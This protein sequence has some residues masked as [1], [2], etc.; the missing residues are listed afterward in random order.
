LAD[1]PVT[2]DL[3]D[4]AKARVDTFSAQHYYPAPP[5]TRTPLIPLSALSLL[6]CRQHGPFISVGLVALAMA[7]AL[8]CY[9]WW[10]RR[11]DDV[12][13]AV[14]PREMVL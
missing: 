6:K 8:L 2:I 4:Q 10:Q 9:D 12:Y 14:P 13:E 7:A 3:V 1:D 11:R 5:G